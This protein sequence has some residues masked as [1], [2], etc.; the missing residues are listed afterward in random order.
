MVLVS[1]V[2]FSQAHIWLLITYL[3]A[4]FDQLLSDICAKQVTKEF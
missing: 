3:P 2:F 4:I 1:S